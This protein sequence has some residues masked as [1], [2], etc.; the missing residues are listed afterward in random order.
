MS[1]KN[2][3]EHNQKFFEDFRKLQGEM[4]P[5]VKKMACGG[6]LVLLVNI[7]LFIGAV[8][9]IALGLKYALTP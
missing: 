1:G 9:I 3:D 7:G 5:S 4:L 6:I 2:Q 8:G